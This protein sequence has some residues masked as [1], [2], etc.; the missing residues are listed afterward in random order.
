MGY[1]DGAAYGLELSLDEG[2]MLVSSVGSSEDITMTSLIVHLMG[3]NWD[4]KTDMHRNLQT[5]IQ[6]GLNLF[7]MKELSWVLMLTTLKDKVMERLMVH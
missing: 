2:T 7:W 1:S 4:E 6:M 5:E 3:S